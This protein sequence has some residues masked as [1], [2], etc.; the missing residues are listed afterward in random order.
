MIDETLRRRIAVD[1]AIF[2]GKPTI[3]RRRIYGDLI[4]GSLAR[5]ETPEF[6]L[7]DYPD[8]GPDE[9]RAY[10][11]QEADCSR[12]TSTCVDSACGQFLSVAEWVGQ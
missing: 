9:L 11:A 6:I 12:I 4:L 2:V 3:R 10:V 1:P 8:L 5:E 7:A